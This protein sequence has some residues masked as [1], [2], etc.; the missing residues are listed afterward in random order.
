MHGV[1]PWLQ[2]VA[3]Q[4]THGECRDPLMDFLSLDPA[5][6]REEPQ[7]PSSQPEATQ[8]G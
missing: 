6:G 8:T 4:L 1:T 2:R 7:V 5:G 3:A